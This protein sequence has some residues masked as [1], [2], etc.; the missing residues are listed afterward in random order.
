MRI[1]LP[2]RTLPCPDPQAHTPAQT[3][4][5]Q[6]ITTAQLRTKPRCAPLKPLAPAGDAL[7]AVE[8]LVVE[9]ATS[10]ILPEHY[11]ERGG[12]RFA[13]PYHFDFRLHAKARMVGRH[14]VD[15]FAAEFPVRGRC[16]AII[17]VMIGGCVLVSVWETDTT[18]N[19]LGGYD[20][21]SACEIVLM[22]RSYPVSQ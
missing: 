12:L 3:S 7:R 21:Q 16:G 13:L 17:D 15:V 22:M 1:R 18:R 19:V 11:V 14:P 20:R 9:D 2:C 10:P 5:P 8:G 4:N 6:P